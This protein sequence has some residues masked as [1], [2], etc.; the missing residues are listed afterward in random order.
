[1][2][3]DNQLPAELPTL[4]D[5]IAQWL[6]FQLPTIPLPQTVRNLD[7]AIAKIVLAG[8]ENVEARIRANTS[9]EKAMGKIN[10]EE[11]VRTEEEKRKIENK[12]STTKIAIGEI[13]S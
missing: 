8:G 10:V 6:G 7:K 12:I 4:R 3:N 5:L 2:S 9:K 11:F 13:N 1:M